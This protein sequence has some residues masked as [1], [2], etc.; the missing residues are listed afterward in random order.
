[1][2]HTAVSC[3]DGVVVRLFR[4]DALALH[5]VGGAIVSDDVEARTPIPVGR[6]L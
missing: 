1:M 6:C 2:L 3:K 4:R 5:G